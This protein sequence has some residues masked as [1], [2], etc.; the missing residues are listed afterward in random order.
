MRDL[1]L[2]ATEMKD[3]DIVMQSGS[4]RVAQRFADAINGSFFFL[5]QGRGMSRVV[6]HESGRPI[7][8]DFADFIG[9][10]LHADLSRRDFT[11]NAMA[12]EL[13]D[14][15]SQ[16]MDA[17]IIDPFS[18]RDDIQNLMIRVVRP[19]VLDDDPLRLLRAVRFAAQLRFTIEPKTAAYIMRR[20]HLISGPA[21]E[22]IKDELFQILSS[23]GAADNLLLM[24]SLGMLLRIFP[25]LAP[26]KGFAPGRYHVYDVLIHSIKTA[27]YVDGVVDDLPRIAP[28][29]AA[30]VSRH[31]EDPM[32]Q[33]VDRKA[34]LRFACLLHDIA[35]P[36]T[37]TEKDGHIRFHGH[38]ALG[39]EKA[40]DICRRLRLS[41][42]VESLV[43]KAIRHHMRL[44]QLA[45]PGGPSS[46]A[47]FR[48]CRDLGDDLPESIVLALADSRS[49]FENMPA[50][51]FLDTE[52]Y[53]A[54]VL[55]YYYRRFLKT[56]EK[57]L[58]TGQDL[59]A[60]GLSPGP[61]F[62]EILDEIRE[63]RAEGTILTRDEALAY[64]E[65]LK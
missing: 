13:R 46:H 4:A 20:S 18:G 33:F 36:E 11:M 8:F 2:K 21:P 40:G 15:L 54:Y 43:T 63:R 26:L 5:D 65:R 30:K 41:R 61:R 48:Y 19:D 24:D 56:E 37:F 6:R 9:P 39:A 60:L 50:E 31:L 32:E 62:K 29:F 57:P 53:A 1:L 17:D 27:D 59:I 35:K 14:Y 47:M 25:E 7:Q 52:K 55:E 28:A 49:T 51:K 34:A 10:D 58:V 22:R 12:V 44:F 64:I 42:G 16:G 23:R 45:T 38:D 3:I